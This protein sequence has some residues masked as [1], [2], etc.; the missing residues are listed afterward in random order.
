[1]RRTL[2]AVEDDFQ[3]VAGPE[4]GSLDPHEAR[5]FTEP[6]DEGTDDETDE[7]EEWEDEE[8]DD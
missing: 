8:E 5:A 4:D 1:M 6:W 2:R 3:D 7:D